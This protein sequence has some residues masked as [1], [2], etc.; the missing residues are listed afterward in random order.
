[1]PKSKKFSR[2]GRKPTASKVRPLS[3]RPN[4]GRSHRNLSG[5]FFPRLPSR[6]Q[7]W[8]LMRR[9]RRIFMRRRNVVE[10]VLL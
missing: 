2:P 8:Q 6:L 1:M 10:A 3:R 4:L 9:V 5:W 7:D